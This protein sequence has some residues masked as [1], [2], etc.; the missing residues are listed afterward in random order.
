[1]PYLNHYLEGC[2]RRYE[3]G[4]HA[5]LLSALDA[6]LSWCQGPP[7]WIVDGFYVAWSKWLRHEALTL[8]A[9]FGLRRSH[10]E[11]HRKRHER[12]MLRPFIVLQVETFRRQGLPLDV[13]LFELVGAEINKSAGFVSKVY[14]DEASA[15]WRAIAQRMSVTRTSAAE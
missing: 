9:A 5:A 11:Q 2:R 1:M 10:P 7:K 8:D 15:G 6:W 13:R 3:R 12:E 4:D 14:Y